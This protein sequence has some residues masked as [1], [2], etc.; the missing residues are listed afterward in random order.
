MITIKTW[1]YR[2]KEKYTYFHNMKSAS[3]SFFFFYSLLKYWKTLKIGKYKP[4]N[5]HLFWLK[6]LMNANER[7]RWDVSSHL[8]GKGKTL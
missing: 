7:D 8:T 6:G 2:N 3:V 5:S 1:K 4:Q